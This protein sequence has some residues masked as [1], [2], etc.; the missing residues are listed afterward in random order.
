MASE[1]L[2]YVP[3]AFTPDNDGLNELFR[4]VIGGGVSGVNYEFSIWD[5][6][7]ERIFFTTDPKEGWNGSVNRGNYYV[8]IDAYV[9]VLKFT[10]LDSG[11]AV[12]RKGHVTLIR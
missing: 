11:N 3:T 1:V 9:W 6:W 2:V 10:E 8:Q 5:R 4:P 7:G 12:E